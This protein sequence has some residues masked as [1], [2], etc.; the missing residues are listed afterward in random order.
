MDKASEQ[1]LSTM[2]WHQLVRE[3]SKGIILQ[4]DSSKRKEAQQAQEIEMLR[5]QIDEMK[6]SSTLSD[7]KLDK[8]LEMLSG[9]NPEDTKKEK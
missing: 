5:A 4:L 3:K 7:A 2:P 6:R 1:A 9:G 8:L